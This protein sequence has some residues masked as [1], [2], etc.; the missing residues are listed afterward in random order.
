[1][2]PTTHS[3]QPDHV[4]A[5]TL[6]SHRVLATDIP[7]GIPGPPYYDARYNGHQ[8]S[9]TW[10]M[11]QDTID[12]NHAPRPAGPRLCKD[13]RHPPSISSRHPAR[14]TGAS[15][16]DQSRTDGYHATA[17][18]IGADTVRCGFVRLRHWC[19]SGIVSVHVNQIEKSP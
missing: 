17:I 6:D 16:H 3:D 4:Y 7:L 11:R 8:P 5:K 18:G 14:H 19:G 1:M 15:V 12:T 9:K 2:I 10:T 13:S